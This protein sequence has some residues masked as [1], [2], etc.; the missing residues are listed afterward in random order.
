MKK[1]T[2]FLVLS[3]VLL[4]S[5]VFAQKVRSE[6]VEYQYV[7]LPLNPIDKSIK[8]YQASI[9]ATYEEDNSQKKAAYEADKKKAEDEFQKDKADHPGKVK[10]AE[11]KYK[12]EM[13]EYKKKSVGEKIIEKKVLGEDNK[14]VKQIPSEPYLR[15]VPM[16]VLK[17]S[18]NYPAVSSTYLNIGGLENK[19]GNEVKYLVTI[20]GYDYTQPMQMTTQKN[21]TS[22]VNGQSTTRPVTY[23][24][25]EFSYRHTMSFTVTLPDGK[26]LMNE[27]PQEL[28][29]YT[30]YKTQETEAYQS[31]NTD[32]LIK[33]TEEK[34]FQQNL[35]FINNLVNERIGFQPVKRNTK[36]FYIKEKGETYQ[37]LLAAYNDAT[38]GMKLLSSNPSEGKA[39][40]ENAVKL[41]DAALVESKPEDKKARIDR[42]VT[43][44]ICFDLLESFF[45]LRLPEKAEGII[46]RLNILKLNYED[47]KV[48][49][50]Y[51]A[52]FLDLKKRIAANP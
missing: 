19:T 10:A 34:I 43:I 33:S 40:I 18:Y 24:Y 15:H 49:E 5:S 42:D 26:M 45:A 38:S 11:D 44:M 14:P 2:T 28:N 13:D 30:V 51:E 1:T 8:N 41:W 20:Y 48:K 27:T 52:L 50:E 22:V 25:L 36:I 31:V 23:Y 35:T 16:P 7:R 29:N 12:V 17:T 32:M 39:K 47:K 37:D 21:I 46:N 9:F 4:S 6:V 3:L